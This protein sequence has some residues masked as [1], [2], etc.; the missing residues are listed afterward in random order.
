MYKIFTAL[1]CGKPIVHSFYYLVIMKIVVLLTFTLVQVA[2]ASHG[3]EVSIRVRNAPI[4]SVLYLLS[5][6]SGYDFIYDARLLQGIPNITLNKH[7]VQLETVLKQCFF[8]QNV[9]FV[10][11]EDRTIIIKEARSLKPLPTASQ[12]QTVVTGT[13]R[14]SL[15]TPI[16]GV[17]VLV[18]GTSS[19]VATD[20]N[21]SFAIQA[22]KGDI[23]VFKNV[24]YESHQVVLADQRALDVV[25]RPI[26]SDL[27]EVVVV[28]YGQQKKM[29][30][31]GAISSIKGEEIAKTKSTSLAVSLAGKV[32][33]LQIR[34]QT[35]MPG[36]FNTNINIRGFGNPLFVID[37]IVR[38]GDKEFQRLNPEEIESISVL[39]DASAAIYGLNSGN[40]VIIVKTK[41]GSKG[42]MRISYSG[43]V[44]L[45]APTT[46]MKVM[47]TRQ[48]EEIRNEAEVNAGRSPLY[49]TPEELE[50]KSSMPDVDWY[51][52]AFKR[53]A[54]QQQN[55]VKLEGGSDKVS[56]FINLGYVTDNGLLK[57]GD[58][59][60]DRYSLRSNVKAEVLKGLTAN[61]N[62]GGY[63]DK[64]YQPGTW[65]DAF[66]YLMKAVHGIIPSERIYANDNPNYWNKPAPINDN[67][68]AFS[69]R[70]EFGYREWRGRTLQTSG[71]L[72]YRI[73]AVEGLTLRILGGFDQRNGIFTR[74][75]K[76]VM[77]YEYSPVEDAY[78]SFGTR[79]PFIQEENTVLNRVDF[80]GS[81]GYEKSISNVHNI[82]AI[83]VFEARE[84]NE[85]YLSGKR[86]YNFYTIDNIDRAPTTGQE[87]G[88][89]TNKATYLS[90]IGRFNYNFK[91]KYLLELAYRYDGSY[92]Y[93]PDQRWGFF[94]VV[95]GA[96]RI[97]EES[98]IRDR[99]PAITN[100]KIRGS[101]GVTGQNAGAA[102]QYIAGFSG[103][104]GYV[105]N[106]GVLT[107]GYGMTGL[108]NNNLTWY[109]STMADIGFD[110]S[111]YNGL[112]DV[113]FDVYRRSREGLLARRLQ[114]LPNTFGA[115]LPEENLE[116]DRTEGFD[117]MIGHRNKAGEVSYSVSMNM[118]FGRTQWIYRE[119]AP[120]RS[121]WDQYRNTQVGRWSDIGWGY[122]V[123]GQFQ[124]YE[125]IRNAPIETT[126]R[127]NGNTLPGDYIH[128][129]TNGDGLIDGKDATPLFWVGHPKM[130]YGMTMN[131]AWSGFDIN[132]LLQGSAFSSARYTEI[133]GN[134][135][136]FGGNSPAYFYDRWRLADPY[137]PN[138]EWIPG[139]LPATRKN[140]YD[141]GSVRL[142][143]NAN[144]FSTAY[145]RVKSVELG[146]TL[147]NASIKGIHN[148]RLYLNGFNLLTFCNEHLRNFDP[149]ILDGNGF[150]YPLS[151]SYNLG[152][153]VTF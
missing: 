3:Q 128:E 133:L 8:D 108:V 14:D 7:N 16:P 141:A 73:P 25:I 47:N 123:L 125:E 29:T 115:A 80:Q 131:A 137:D 1:R 148:L 2:V 103:Q 91:E 136:T 98:F 39:K 15:G 120:F 121:S 65:D 34:Q 19:G 52:A 23:L 84:E 48:F 152:V 69:R 43:L 88:G 35:G 38:D 41:S 9:E 117:L 87:A 89:W 130:H 57:S 28:G 97:S 147:P 83:L 6:Q 139:K 143:S 119:R 46:R 21:G 51:G 53:S 22:Q 54:W 30:L 36:E 75:Q 59:G 116:K 60:Y 77:L 62:I 17:S 113:E 99:V 55:N 142:E 33:G 66:F 12:I 126:D 45:S 124:D 85:R 111:L 32:P 68:I 78:Q 26:F 146:Y 93:H 58:V 105:F 107:N 64:R 63:V 20:S 61:V 102:H 5:Q 114:A 144:R 94:P 74:V 86:L 92:R 150:N 149:E 138:S 18:Q 11:N 27:E 96:W 95:S 112:L 100:L 44:G 82:N 153:N 13:V 118:N 90:Q 145:L 70:E 31:S 134:V 129:D 42:P 151:V 4:N 40:G 56:S 81:I 110:L 76:N 104:G 10:F 72:T 132:V 140:D 127:A 106:D 24:G 101:Y 109:T 122:N 49:A 135:L 37:G 71:D 79:Q 67:P 50:A